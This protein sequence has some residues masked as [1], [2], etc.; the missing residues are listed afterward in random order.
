MSEVPPQAEFEVLTDSDIA[1]H[2]AAARK[3]QPP[4]EWQVRFHRRWRAFWGRPP[5]PLLPDELPH[6]FSWDDPRCVRAV[7]QEIANDCQ[8]EAERLRGRVSVDLDRVRESLRELKAIEGRFDAEVVR[9]ETGPAKTLAEERRD[10]A[11]RLV[12]ELRA[13][14]SR[15]VSEDTAIREAIKPVTDALDQLD[16]LTRIGDG[17]AVLQEASGLAAAAEQRRRQRREEIEVL[18][19]IAERT[20]QR[21]DGLSQ[22]LDMREQAML[23]LDHLA[24]TSSAPLPEVQEERQTLSE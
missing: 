6:A 15:L 23:E 7:A 16:T 24:R 22:T 18:R 17:L 21:L 19:Q 5:L 14:E 13:L 20:R 10:E 3:R 4:L 1:R 2:Y 8:A 11:T 9:A 12:K